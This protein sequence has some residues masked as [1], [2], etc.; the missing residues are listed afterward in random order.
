LHRL[1]VIRQELNE[2][3]LK[4]IDLLERRDYLGCRAD[5]LESHVVQR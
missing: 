4:P 1:T 5:E 2:I 3:V